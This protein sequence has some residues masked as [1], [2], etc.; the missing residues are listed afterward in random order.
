MPQSSSRSRPAGVAELFGLTRGDDGAL[1]AAHLAQLAATW[2][3][4]LA[5][6][7]IA[8]AVLIAGTGHAVTR[9]TLSI[10][11][12]TL[13]LG[14]AMYALLTVGRRF[15]VHAR[16]IGTAAIAGVDAALLL[17]LLWA[18]A[19]SAGGS[20]QVAGSSPCSSQ[21]GS[22]PRRGSRC[23]AWRASPS[24]CCVWPGSTARPP[25][26]A[27]TKQAKGAPPPR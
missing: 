27:R 22:V 17:T 4:A 5:A 25:T 18:A 6:Q 23:C 1:D 7:M 2:P 3:I 24:R 12:G 10:G 9:F 16:V 21:P 8:I 11:T 19:A 14:G 15:A 20:F 26:R 13:M